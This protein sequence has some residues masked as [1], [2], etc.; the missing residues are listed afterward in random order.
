MVGRDDCV[1]VACGIDGVWSD[2]V[3]RVV[4]LTVGG[5]VWHEGQMEKKRNW[6]GKPGGWG[7]VLMLRPLGLI[8]AKCR[9]FELSARFPNVLLFMMFICIC[10][11]T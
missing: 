9:S 3:C 7:A 11:S 5:A 6:R 1:V 10:L 2:D 8:V 4:V